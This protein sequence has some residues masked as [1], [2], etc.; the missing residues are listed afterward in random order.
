MFLILPI[1]F[2]LWE[3][4]TCLFNFEQFS[5]TTDTIFL[6]EIRIF[7]LY[8]ITLYIFAWLM[9]WIWAWFFFTNVVGRYWATAPLSLDLFTHDPAKCLESTAIEKNCYLFFSLPG[10]RV[11]Y[12]HRVARSSFW[13]FLINDLLC[14]KVSLYNT[15]M[16]FSGTV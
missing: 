2:H 16:L 1:I 6:V 4:P 15:F 5:F 7:K 11:F 8:F 10:Y 3:S 9:S 13:Q 14:R 12:P